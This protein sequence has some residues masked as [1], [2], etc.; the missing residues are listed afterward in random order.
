MLLLVTNTFLVSCLTLLIADIQ[1]VS[2]RCYTLSHLHI[3]GELFDT[4][5]KQKEAQS[6]HAESTHKEVWGCTSAGVYVPC[7][8]TH[9]RWELP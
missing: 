7:I 4:S 6:A 9:V 8:Y 1:L 2:Y 3:F 5:L